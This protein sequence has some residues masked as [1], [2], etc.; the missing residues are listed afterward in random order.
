M[1]HR[2]NLNH[3]GRY[4]KKN[5]DAIIRKLFNQP[6][7][8][9][10]A[11]IKNGLQFVCDIEPEFYIILQDTVKKITGKRMPMNELTHT[12][13]AWFVKTYRNTNMPERT[14]PFEQIHP[15]KRHKKLAMFQRKFRCHYTNRFVSIKE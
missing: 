3:E 1:K 10:D 7:N 13:L 12:L 14:L 4:S 15:G 9:M 11:S 8:S 5:V 6:K 2:L